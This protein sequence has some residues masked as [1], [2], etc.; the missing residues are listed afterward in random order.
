MALPFGSQSFDLVVSTQVIEHVPDDQAFVR[1][2][3][4]VLTSGGL[5]V[6]SSVIKMHF[7]WYF[8]RN[9]QGE[10]VLDPT[11]VREYSSA[12]EFTDLFQERFRIL[13]STIERFKFSPVRFVYRLLI[14]LGIIRNPDPQIFS[15]SRWAALLGRWAV[16][17]PRYRRIIVVA[18]SNPADASTNPR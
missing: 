4:R 18:E 7:G 9:K 2:I 16:T 3:K 15:K 13:S 14:K 10:R 8:Y 12:Q 1:E 5:C 11:H 17:V 6:V